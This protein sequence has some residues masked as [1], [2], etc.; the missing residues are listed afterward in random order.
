MFPTQ[1]K[2]KKKKAIIQVGGTH[3]HTK[4]NQL[5]QTTGIGN[6]NSLKDMAVLNLK[7][8]TVLTKNVT[9]VIT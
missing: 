6:I 7:T 3:T 9:D 8:I 2:K 1:T 4:I 5:I